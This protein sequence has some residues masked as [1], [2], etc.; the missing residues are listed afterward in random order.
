[1]AT[2]VAQRERSRIKRYASALSN[3]LISP[4]LRI[5]YRSEVNIEMVTEGH[6]S[7]HF[8]SY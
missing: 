7:T 5:P 2:D 8:Q 6:V 1:M 3:T 4:H